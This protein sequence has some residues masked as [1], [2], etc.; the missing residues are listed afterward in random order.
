MLCS[1]GKAQ[2]LLRDG[3]AKIFGYEPFTVRL[4]AATGE[5][6]KEVRACVDT[7][8]RHIGL[9]VVSEGRVLYIAEID[10]GST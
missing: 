10:C 3:K 5:T 9:A 6:V 2:V 7:G 1:P 4:L 8:S